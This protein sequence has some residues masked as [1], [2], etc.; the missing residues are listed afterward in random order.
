VSTL[1]DSGPPPLPDPPPEGP[2][3]RLLRAPFFEIGP[4]NLLRKGE[5]L[6][7]CEI[8]EL[9]SA[10]ENVTVVVTV[11]ATDIE[12]I[13][14]R[15]P[16]LV[17]AA[18]HMDADPLGTSVG[19][20][21]AEALLDAGADGVMLNHSAHPLTEQELIATAARA[22]EVGLFAIGTAGTA[23]ELS[24]ALTAKVD[25]V[26]Y[27]PVELIGKRVRSERPW[28]E[29]INHD[30]RN[31]NPATLMMHA[32]GISAAADAFEVMRAGADGT[33]AT[34]AVVLALDPEW[35]LRGMLRSVRRGWE[36]AQA[37][38]ELDLVTAE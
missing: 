7:L 14:S 29:G 11:P 2:S 27:E 9:V 10:E 30:V 25:V 20:T 6:D 33:G 28:I 12:S 23:E 15:F 19:R 21:I 17:V 4:K 34:S 1:S 31:T 5:L 26:L 13:A 8:A 22:R 35:A 18:Q 36:I 38:T 37:A 3:A 32:G 24:T 16:G